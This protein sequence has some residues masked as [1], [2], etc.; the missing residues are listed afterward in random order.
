MHTYT[1]NGY[2]ALIWAAYRPRELFLR[3]LL[4]A[5]ADMK[6]K[7]NVRLVGCDVAHKF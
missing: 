2:T 1:Q 7:C 5:G 6:V 3:L 4:D